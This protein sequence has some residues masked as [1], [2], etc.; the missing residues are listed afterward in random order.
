MGK[1]EKRSGACVTKRGRTEDVMV[2]TDEKEAEIEAMLSLPSRVGG[3][4]G[5]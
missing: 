4:V 1:T 2:A 3:V 5:I